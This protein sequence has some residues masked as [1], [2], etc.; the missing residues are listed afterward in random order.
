M[1]K[2]LNFLVLAIVLITFASCS[3]DKDYFDPNKAAELKKAEYEAAFVKKYGKIATDQ[4]WGFGE[5]INSRA[6]NPNSNQWEN[7]TVVPGNITAEEKE[8]VTNWFKTHQNPT[9]I[10]INWTDF[11]VQQISSSHSNMDKLFAV[12]PNKVEEHINNFNNG[13]GTIM[14]M[15]NSG[16]SAF[17]YNNSMDGKSHYKYTIQYIDGAYYVGI[18]FEATGTNSNQQEAADGYY[19]DW[20]VKI[21]PAKYINAKRVMAE[22]L[23]EIGDFD[24]NDVVFDAVILDNTAIITLQAAGGTLP[25]YIG[26]QTNENEVHN[27]FS[28]ST[29][30]MVNT[31]SGKHQEIP[32]VIFRLSGYSDIKN[33]PIIIDNNGVITTLSA[34]QGKAPGKICIP[35]T[36]TDWSNERVSIEDTYPNFTKYVGDSS[37]EWW[38]K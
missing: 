35:N 1:K 13:Q 19:A 3:S 30:T 18:D 23:G 33:I 6:A 28:V 22:D 24:F 36:T 21:T 2:R 29:T 38:N 14:L 26:N 25:L 8:K 32:P 17:G 7:F 20:I 12:L 4:Y 34:D 37:I 9:S 27:R 11:F 5:N 31:Q 15:Q 10:S 16:T